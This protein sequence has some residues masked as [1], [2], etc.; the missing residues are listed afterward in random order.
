MLEA[1]T[2]KDAS[3]LSWQIL[4]NSLYDWAEELY[5]HEEH[6]VS[7]GKQHENLEYTEDDQG[8][9]WWEVLWYRPEISS[10]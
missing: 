4:L 2:S 5:E 10:S 6:V 1:T 8:D 9:H 3:V 7:E